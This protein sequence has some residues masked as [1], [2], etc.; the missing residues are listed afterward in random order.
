MGSDGAT[1]TGKLTW[2]VCC[3]GNKV[4]DWL[5]MALHAALLSHTKCYTWT[6]PNNIC[7]HIATAKQILVFTGEK[8]LS[9][10]TTQSSKCLVSALHY[11][12]LRLLL[13]K[14]LLFLPPQRSISWC[15]SVEHQSGVKRR[16]QNVAL[17]L[18]LWRP[19]SKTGWFYVIM[20]VTGAHIHI[21]INKICLSETSLTVFTPALKCFM[22]DFIL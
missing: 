10:P 2:V 16:V 12:L 19:D 8:A 4:A 17:A 15:M 7:D 13:V 18:R 21:K 22:V 5:R 20:S 14:K 6:Q 1:A 3:Y 11:G 9:P